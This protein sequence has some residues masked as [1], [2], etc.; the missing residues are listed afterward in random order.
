LIVLDRFFDSLRGS[1]IVGANFLKIV[2]RSVA[3]VRCFLDIVRCSLAIVRYSAVIVPN[4]L[5]AVT[6]NVSGAPC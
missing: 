4:S 3:I 6:A 2:R 5:V 1:T